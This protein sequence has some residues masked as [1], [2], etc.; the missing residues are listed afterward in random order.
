MNL[1]QISYFSC[2]K[3]RMKLLA[4]LPKFLFKHDLVILSKVVCDT[5]DISLAD[6]K[7]MSKIDLSEIA[8]LH[9]SHHR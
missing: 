8:G 9:I 7:I 4:V 6:C 5:T 3:Y 2:T 1:Q